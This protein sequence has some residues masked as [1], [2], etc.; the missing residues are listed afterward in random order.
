M[1]GV[2]RTC[3]DDSRDTLLWKTPDD[4]PHTARLI[5]ARRVAT[6]SRKR[7]QLHLARGPQ[8]ERSPGDTRERGARLTA[9][10][11]LERVGGVD[12]RTVAEY[13]G[14]A[15]PGFTLRS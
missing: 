8:D 10:G 1:P 4:P 6:P 13:L 15:D 9:H 3:G 14:H 11:G 12:I 7:L 2:P 5:A